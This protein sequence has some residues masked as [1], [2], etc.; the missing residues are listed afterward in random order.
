MTD[1]IL[2]QDEVRKRLRKLGMTYRNAKIGSAIAVVEA[3]AR[4]EPVPSSDFSK[5]G[6]QALANETWGYSYGGFQIRSLRSQKGTGE[7]RDEDRLGEPQFNCH[8]AKIIH[9]T[10]GWKAWSTFTSGQYKAYLQDIYPPPPN[11]YVVLVDDT[12]TGIGEKLGIDWEELARVNNLHS[13]YTIYI[14]QYLTLP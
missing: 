3:P 6:D 8:S 10:T 2:T 1:Y 5:V 4:G 13:P 7:F 14:G 11:T 9:D 12:L